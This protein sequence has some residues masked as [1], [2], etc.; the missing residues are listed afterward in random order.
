[1]RREADEYVVDV[2]R[3]A[4]RASVAAGTWVR[5]HGT[6][7]AFPSKAAARDW[8]REVS[9]GRTVWV[10]DA[11]AADSDPVDGYLVARRYDPERTR[12]R[13]QAAAT[14]QTTLDGA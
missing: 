5:E 9:D 7:K 2:K 13:E 6:R 3:S 11:N 1:V 8:A 14:A 4:R 12:A 10:Q